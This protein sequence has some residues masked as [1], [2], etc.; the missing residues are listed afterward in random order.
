MAVML[1]IFVVLVIAME[2]FG[3]SD[4]CR[5]GDD[6]GH[7]LHAKDKAGTPAVSAMDDVYDIHS[8]AD[9]NKGI[10]DPSIMPYL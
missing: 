3:T 4:A 7:H 10:T 2:Y 9:I 5:P 6:S 8:I 1:L